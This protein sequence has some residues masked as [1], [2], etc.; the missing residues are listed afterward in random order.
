MTMNIIEHLEN[1]FGRISQGWKDEEH[2]PGIQVVCF[3]HRPIESVDTFV[4]LGMSNHVLNISD[5]KKVR[6]EL[7][8]TVSSPS[9]QHLL[10]SSLLFICDLMLAKHDALLRGQ[11]IRLPEEVT[12][13]LGFY[14]MYCSIPVFLEGDFATFSGSE[15]PTVMVWVI[16]IYKTEADFIAANGWSKFEDVLEK[17][18][19]DLFSLDRKPA[20]C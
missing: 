17:E 8:I 15:P 4:T 13:K 14:A 2:H 20:I 7:V 3:K 9:I 10:I 11:V 6:Q 5:S 12:D 18:D 19:T 1:C 16:P